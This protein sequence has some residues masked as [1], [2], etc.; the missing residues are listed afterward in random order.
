MQA[1]KECKRCGTCCKKGGPILHIEDLP[2]CRKGV[3]PIHKLITI[4][5]GEPSFNPFSE[6]VEPAKQEMIK[7]AGKGASWECVFYDAAPSSCTIHADR[8]LE[9]RQLECWDTTQ[10]A[11]VYGKNCLNRFALINENEPIL[12]LI[13]DHERQCS[14]LAAL[15]IIDRMAAGSVSSGDLEKLTKLMQDDL[16]LRDRAVSALSLSLAQELFYFGRPLFQTL[17]HPAL[18]VTLDGGC[19]RLE[20]NG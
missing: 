2:L 5:K 19:I 9:C 3:L 1:E 18:R 4:R 15:P 20:T 11:A 17:Q 7:V 6:Q 12:R 13:K 14:Y 16:V 8:P 10:I